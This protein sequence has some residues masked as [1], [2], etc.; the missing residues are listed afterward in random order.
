MP[1]EFS[2][3]SLAQPL[4]PREAKRV[5]RNALLPVDRAVMWPVERF[6][7]ERQQRRELFY[8]DCVLGVIWGLI[9]LCLIGVIMRGGL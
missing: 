6:E 9:G 1:N 7:L 8:L 2:P 4:K 3:R 5:R